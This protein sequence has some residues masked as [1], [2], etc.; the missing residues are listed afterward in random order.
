MGEEDVAGRAGLGRLHGNLSWG[1]DEEFH[2]QRWEGRDAQ[3]RKNSKGLERGL[4]L[5]R[6]AWRLCVSTSWRVFMEP[7][8]RATSCAACW[9]VISSGPARSRCAAELPFYRGRPWGLD[10]RRHPGAHRAHGT[11]WPPPMSPPWLLGLAPHLPSGSLALL[12]MASRFLL[13]CGHVVGVASRSL[14]RTTSFTARNQARPLGCPGGLRCLRLWPWH[15]PGSSQPHAR[16]SP[17]QCRDSG[18]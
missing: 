5:C 4:G 13:P 7:R 8:P 2:G 1:E 17:P 3:G 6:W 9:H 11:R 12:R 16:C 18:Q 10:D 15:C 14:A